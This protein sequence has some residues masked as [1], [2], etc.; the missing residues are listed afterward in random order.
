MKTRYTDAEIS[1]HYTVW[2]ENLDTVI[3]K[4]V[5]YPDPWATIFYRF[6]QNLAFQYP[7]II[8]GNVVSKNTGKIRTIY[9]PKFFWE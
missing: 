4:H 3:T 1:L 7:H 5:L 6:L 2:R 9:F 8:I